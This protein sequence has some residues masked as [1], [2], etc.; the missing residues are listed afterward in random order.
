MRIYYKIKRMKIMRV[1]GE[2]AALSCNKYEVQ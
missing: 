2:S 1:I